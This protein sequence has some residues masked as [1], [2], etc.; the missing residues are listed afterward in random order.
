[1]K[2]HNGYDSCPHC[3]HVFEPGI[4]KKP[5][6]GGARCF[7]P[8]NSRWRRRVVRADGHVY[9][10]TTDETR[11]EPALRTTQSAAENCHFATRS[12]PVRGHK[13]IP[14]M[15]SWP[16]FSWDM[17]TCDPMH[18][19]KNVCDMV[20]KGTV[21]K[22]RHGMY[23]HWKPNYDYNHRLHCEVHNIF[24]EVHDENNPLPWRL[25]RQDV[26]DLDTRVRNMWW[27]HYMD[28]VCRN[29]FSFWRKSNRMWKCSHKSLI[30][31]VGVASPSCSIY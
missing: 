14:L 9:T 8:R 16:S 7:L 12:R 22:G 4:F 3:H 24:P 10:F 29:G 2:N 21:G 26:I 20:L 28:V 30:L 1:M 6:Y 5:C 25:T 15:S 17:G 19:L 27:P 31:L 23:Q 11:R 18:D 13:G